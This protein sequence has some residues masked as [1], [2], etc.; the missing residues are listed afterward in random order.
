MPP[1]LHVLRQGDGSLVTLT[2]KGASGDVPFLWGSVVG[3][4]H[5]QTP[6]LGNS[7]YIFSGRKTDP[8]VVGFSVYVILIYGQK[9]PPVN[10][11]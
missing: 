5:L 2:E 10:H 11:K 9:L 4:F 7:N 1:F 6:P 3:C 8:L